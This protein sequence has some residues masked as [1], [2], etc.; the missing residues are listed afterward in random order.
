MKGNL[1]IVVGPTAVGKT[2]FGVKLA[3]YFNSD[4]ISCDSRQLYKEMSIGTA[5]PSVEEMQGVKHHFI[6]SHSVANLYSA[7]DFERDV[8]NL[9]ETYFEKKNVAILLGGTGLFVKAVTEG[10]DAMPAAPEELRLQLM[11]RLESEGL[12]ILQNELA[13][14]DPIGFN[15]MDIQNSQRVVRALEVCLST[16]KPFSSFKIKEKKQHNFNVIKIGL[17]REREELYARINQRVDLMLE[18]GLLAEVNALVDFEKNNALQTVGYKEVFGFFRGEYE[19]PE[20]VELLKRNTRRYAK[21]QMTWFKNQDTFEWF[22]PDELEE[23]IN[24]I[25]KQLI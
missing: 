7:G 17:E 10:L 12:E 1:I 3:K 13:K 4:V 19:Y 5:K 25:K 14:L 18:G 22:H 15:E 24:Y 23:V 20:M 16:G 6:D 21:R 8:D 2:D 9:L 11:A